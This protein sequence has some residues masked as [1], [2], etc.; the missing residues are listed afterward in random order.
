[1]SRLGDYLSAPEREKTPSWQAPMATQLGIGPS[2]EQSGV[3]SSHS[4][5]EAGI[6]AQLVAFDGV[7]VAWGDAVVLCRVTFRL[8]VV[9][10][11]VV[12]GPTAAGK[13]TLL[14]AI[15]G[16]ATTA[17]GSVKRAARWE[18][19]E[20]IAYAPQVPWIL[21]V[22][23]RD[24]ILMGRPFEAGRYEGLLRALQLTP[25]LLAMPDGE[26]TVLGERGHVLSGGQKARIGL[27]RALYSSRSALVLLD[28]CL[29]S[30]DNTVA[31]RIL[32]D[33]ILPC[34]RRCCTVLVSHSRQ[35]CCHATQILEVSDGTLT[36]AKP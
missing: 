25:D 34:S 15:L 18:E 10:L 33:A 32:E 36:Q 26:H 12:T 14:A 19:D 17:R 6:D 3:G 11:S 35:P 23:V 22:S 30:L 8:P 29:A 9:G 13:S 28:D 1:M 7:D 31:A 24:N 27:A 4:C 20:A 21:N 16:E 2:S 5:G